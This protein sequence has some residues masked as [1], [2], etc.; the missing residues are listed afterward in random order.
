MKDWR[1]RRSLRLR[2][3][4]WYAATSLIILLAL[5]ALLLTLVRYRLNAELDRQLRSDSEFVSARLE[6]DD[7]GGVR[8]DYEIEDSR[9]PERVGRHDGEDEHERPHTAAWFE[10]WSPDSKLLLR[11][12]PGEENARLGGLA[13]VPP[14]LGGNNSATRMFSAQLG[15]LPVRVL[16][17][18]IQIDNTPATLR[19][20]RSESDLRSALAQIGA[21]LA[22]GLPLAAI[23]SAASGYLI[24]RKS[25]SPLGAMAARARQITAERLSAR[26]P[27]SNPQDELGQLAAVF[28]ETL[29]RLENSFAELRRFAADASHELRTPLTALRAVGEASLRE[30]NDSNAAGAW[31]EAVGSMLE[32]AQH[33]SELVDALLF[34]ARADSGAS[35]PPQ[36]EAVVLEPLLAEARES[37]LAL[38]EEKVQRIAVEIGPSVVNLTARVDRALL[39]Q[40][41]L[42][43]IHNAIRYSPR[44]TV[45]RLRLRRREEGNDRAAVVEVADEGPGIAPE[46]RDKVFE[47][48]YR[49]DKARSREEGS[50]AGLGLAIARWAVERQGGR[51]ELD[52]APGAGSVFRVVLPA[53]KLNEV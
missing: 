49:I 43:L 45:I 52:S 35:A 19:V 13:L 12:R 34:L 40:A 39:R 48:F 32:E 26:L 28:N 38:A 18:A 36:L 30:K 47:R 20:I 41:L 4:L 1:P 21:V 9:E 46:H 23:L 51:I 24:A 50:G 15:R 53:G 5:G 10:V 14:A 25:L 33:L 22:L 2:L 7:A 17:R 31:R 27:I 8:L 16:D 6:H 37:L 3:T 44:E 42:N 11:R 29:G